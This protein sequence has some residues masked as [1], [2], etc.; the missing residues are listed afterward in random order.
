MGTEVQLHRNQTEGGSFREADAELAAS[1]GQFA[2][3]GTPSPPVRQQTLAQRHIVCT[4]RVVRE[5]W[6]CSNLY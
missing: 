5:V 4:E 3:G 2:E 6:F 1:I